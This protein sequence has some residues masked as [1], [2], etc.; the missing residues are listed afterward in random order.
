MNQ[1]Q[2][3]FTLIELMVVVAIIG[4][5]AAI[6]LPAY[7]DYTI[8]ARVS[9]GLLAAEECKTSVSE[10]AVTHGALPRNLTNAGCTSVRTRFVQRVRVNRG[11]IRVTLT[12]DSALGGAAGMVINLTPSPLVNNA[13]T[14]WTCSS[15]MEQYMPGSCRS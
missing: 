13:I 1:I 14:S 15:T 7:W 12:N 10:Y 9:E 3:G 8:R 11:E 2:R 5:L 6:A 4:V